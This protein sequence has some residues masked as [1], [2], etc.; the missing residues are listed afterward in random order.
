[1]E[2][3]D[4]LIQQ[5]RGGAIER[6]AE[7]IRLFQRPVWRVVAAMLPDHEQGREVLQQV[8]VDAY[9]HL[10]QYRLGTDFSQWLKA[11]ARNRVRAVLRRLCRESKRLAIYRE[12]LLSTLKEDGAN[13]AYQEALADCRQRLSSLASEAI[14][15][16][17]AEGQSFERMAVTLKTTQTAV[18]K[19]LS[20]ARA[21]LKDCIERKLAHS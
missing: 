18:Q 10:D 2:E 17:Y 6:F 21:A 3:L 16:R 12:H 19:L 14:Q 9:I 13:K 8:F 5:V 4:E 7:V 1:M 11:I 15:M 20:R